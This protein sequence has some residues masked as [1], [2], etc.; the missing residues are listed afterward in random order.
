MYKLKT[1][2]TAKKRVKITGTGKLLRKKVKTSHL[3]RK[4]STNKRLRKSAGSSIDN[5]GHKKIMKRLL[6]KHAKKV[7]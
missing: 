7:K 6:N 3:K 1:R 2:K 5:R 4:W